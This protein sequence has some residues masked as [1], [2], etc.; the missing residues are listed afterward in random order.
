MIPYLAVAAIV[1]LIWLKLTR[2][3]ERE[4]LQA[5]NEAYER[6]QRLRQIASDD[7]E[8]TGGYFST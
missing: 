4:R 3:I 7:D 5:M 1:L 2:K 8:K 6:N